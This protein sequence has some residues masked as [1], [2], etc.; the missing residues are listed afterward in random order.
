MFSVKF[1]QLCYSSEKFLLIQEQIACII[2]ELAFFQHRLGKR[3]MSFTAV[4]LDKK[5]KIPLY[6]RHAGVPVMA[7]FSEY[8]VRSSVH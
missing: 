1:T 2:V 6:H 7:Q 5:I 4:A 3:T 8:I